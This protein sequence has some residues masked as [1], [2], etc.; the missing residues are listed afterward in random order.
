[1]IR[2]AGSCPHSPSREGHRNGDRFHRTRWHVD[3]EPAHLTACDT[4]ELPAQMVDVPIVLIGNARLQGGEPSERR[5]R[6]PSEETR[7]EG[8]PDYSLDASWSLA[9][10][11]L[12]RRFSVCIALAR[13]G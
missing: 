3:D 2:F 12:R 4:G 8:E 1:M 7:E 9:Q 11:R 5:P 6:G 13:P 10:A